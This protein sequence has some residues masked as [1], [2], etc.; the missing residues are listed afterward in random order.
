[1]NSFA[2]A[3]ERS[4]SRTSNVVCLLDGRKLASQTADRLCIEVVFE[5][6]HLV[7]KDLEHGLHGALG[8]SH[9]LE[10]R[11]VSFAGVVQQSLTVAAQ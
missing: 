10:Q 6:E 4:I 2:S 5:G 7:L 11:S 9:G 8:L 1:M 3:M